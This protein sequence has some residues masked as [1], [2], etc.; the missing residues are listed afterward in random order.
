MS[1][2][3]TAPKLIAHCRVTNE[4]AKRLQAKM[5]KDA[6]DSDAV[7]AAAPAAVKAML[8]NERLFDHQ[9][10]SVTEKLASSHVACIEMIGVLSQHRNASEIDTVS[11]IGTAGGSEKKAS[12]VHMAGAAI[13]DYDEQDGGAFRNAIFG[14]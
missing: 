13:A 4:I 3:T 11:A 10:E 1:T 2:P 6:A 7:R 5:E 14:R 8:E 9:A 12:A